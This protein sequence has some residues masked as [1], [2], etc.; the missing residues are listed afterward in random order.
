MGRRDVRALTSAVT[1]ECWQGVP[2]V[3]D[4]RAENKIE[5]EA[6]FRVHGLV[7][8]GTAGRHVL[9]PIEKGYK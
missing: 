1:R 3:L 9:V 8:W 2:G 7:H 5:S 4:A 6:R